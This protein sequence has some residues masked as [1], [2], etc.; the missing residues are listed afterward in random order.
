M[1]PKGPAPQRGSAALSHSLNHRVP[2]EDKAGKVHLKA[3]GLLAQREYLDL[4]GRDLGQRTEHQGS[5][6]LEPR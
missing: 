4:A 5:R 2:G 3:F 1:A 6:S